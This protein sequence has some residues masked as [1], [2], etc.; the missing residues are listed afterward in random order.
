MR[1]RVCV[2]TL[3]CTSAHEFGCTCKCAFVKTRVIALSMYHVSYHSPGKTSNLRCINLTN[4]LLMNVTLIVEYE[5][6]K[7][8]T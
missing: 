5:I 7:H 2:R 1:V 8:E 3:E 6:E 4:V